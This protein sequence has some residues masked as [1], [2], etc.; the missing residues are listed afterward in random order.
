[1]AI[2]E[3]FEDPLWK[4]LLVIFVSLSVYDV[5][6]SYWGETSLKKLENFDFFANL[7]KNSHFLPENEPKGPQGP[8]GTPQDDKNCFFELPGYENPMVGKR[9]FDLSPIEK[10][11]C[12][13]TRHLAAI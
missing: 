3:A 2:F 7:S 9:I 13:Q 8:I 1:M 12:Y 4:I 10:S 5:L 11:W 6:K